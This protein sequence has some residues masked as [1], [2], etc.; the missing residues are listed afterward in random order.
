MLKILKTCCGE[1]L[2][3]Y[4]VFNTYTKKF[5]ILNLSVDDAC[6]IPAESISPLYAYGNGL[7]DYV[8]VSKFELLH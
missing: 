4:V 2:N 1:E 5:V 7:F 8:E 3:E 6:L